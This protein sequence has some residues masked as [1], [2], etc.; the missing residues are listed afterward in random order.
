[1][2]NQEAEGAMADS[3]KRPL[4]AQILSI[5]AG[6]DFKKILDAVKGS[7][8]D[9]SNVLKEVQ[10]R[11]NEVK[12]LEERIRKRQERLNEIDAK[13]E[14]LAN[15][16]KALEADI[17][18]IRSRIKVQSPEDVRKATGADLLD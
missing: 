4:L 3:T 12:E 14:E 6:D 5:L 15:K 11:A 17:S 1:M 9:F 7:P 13:L 16:N 18:V 10:D 8:Q 2:S